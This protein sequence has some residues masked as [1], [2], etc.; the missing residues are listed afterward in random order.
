CPAPSFTS[1][2][3]SVAALSFV[4]ATARSVT[5]AGGPA[6]TLTVTCACPL[7]PSLVA[8]IAVLPAATALTR[9]LLSTLATA[10][11]PLV[12]LTGRPDRAPPLASF[13]VAVSCCAEPTVRLALGGVTVTDATGVG[14]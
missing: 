9:P 5:V 7:L 10:G 8:V 14:T 1:V 4:D 6:G 12:Q 13:G 2:N 11:L 3:D